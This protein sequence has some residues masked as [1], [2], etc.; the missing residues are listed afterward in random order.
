MLHG[1]ILRPAAFEA[2]LASLDAAKAEAHPRRQGRARR[3][4]RRRRRAGSLDRRARPRRARC[5][6]EVDRKPRASP[7][8]RP[9]S[10]TS[11]RTPRPRPTSA[12]SRASQG[13]TS[14]RAS[15]P[16]TSSSRRPTPSSTS[17]TRRSSRAP[18]SPSG[19]GDKLTVWTGT[20]RPFAVREELAAAL[21][22]PT[23][24][25]RV[26]RARHRLRLRRQAHR[27]R[28]DRGRAP[29]EGGR[30][31]G[32]GRLDAR[33]GVHLGVP[34]PGRRHR[35]PQRRAQGRHARRVGVPQLQLRPRRH[36]DALRRRQPEDPVPPRQV[37]AAP[38]LLPRARR[39]RQPLRAREPHG[40]ARARARRWIR[41]RSA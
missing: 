1:K 18:R 16:P 38:G 4:L 7:R 33:G 2:T 31:A 22:I 19:S 11:R 13:S 20:Q 27:R 34:P 25:V 21:R 10:S 29:R 14:S 24:N 5:R 30:Q 40:R 32:Q 28:R 15:P 3:R 39:D 8:T 26:H 17:P 35:G 36:R 41:S 12:P 9:S 6:R 37:A 23:E